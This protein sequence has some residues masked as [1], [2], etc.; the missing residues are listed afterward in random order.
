[1]EWSALILI[2]V[3][4]ALLLLNVPIS[5]CIGLADFMHYVAVDGFIAGC[6]YAGAA[7]GGW[8]K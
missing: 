5:F 6:H 4:F 3:F 1:M 7:Y 2:T 8:L